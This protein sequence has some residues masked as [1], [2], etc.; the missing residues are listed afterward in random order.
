M[1]S[2]DK[3]SND[4]K[5]FDYWQKNLI[6]ALIYLCKRGW[7]NSQFHLSKCKGGHKKAV[8]QT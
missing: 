5:R 8:E 3:I 6:I 4:K 1:K 7:V 2:C